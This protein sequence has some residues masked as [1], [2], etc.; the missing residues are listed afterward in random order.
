MAIGRI[1]GITIELSADTTKAVKS[2]DEFERASN[3]VATKLREINTVLKLNPASTVALSQKQEMLALRVSKVREQLAMEKEALRQLGNTP[4][5]EETIEA[6]RRLKLQIEETTVKLYEAEAAYRSFGSV[7][8]QQMAGVGKQLNTFGTKVSTV[9]S[10]L[11]RTLTLPVALL[12]GAAVKE[13]A[14]F[15]NSMAAVGAVS[16]A[17]GEE[18]DQMSSYAREL[19]ATTKFTAND[20]TDAYHY[21]ALAGWE[22]IE[23]MDGLE[24]VLNLV[25][26]SGEDLGTVSDIV[27]D[28]LTAMGEEADQ[29]GRF[30]DVF[31]VTMSKANTN[32]AQ[33]GD[34]FKY[35]APVAGAMGYEIEDLATAL[36]TMANSGIKGSMAGTA[37]RNILT[38]MVHPTDAMQA[39]MDE[40]GV[41]LYD[42]TGKMYSMAEV[43]GQLRSGLGNLAGNFLA[44]STEAQQLNAELEEGTITEDEYAEAIK[45]LIAA[46]YGAEEAHKAE[47]AAML[48]GKRGMSGLLAIVG[49]S[50]EDWNDLSESIYGSKD[51]AQTMR[52]TMENTL[53]GQL[54]ILKSQVAELAMQFG[55]AMLPSIRSI[56]G[57]LKNFVVGLQQMS[58]ETKAMIVKIAALAAAIGPLLF[59]GGKLLSGIGKL[60]MMPAG[61]TKGIAMVTTGF[62]RFSATL[63]IATGPLA[64]IVAGI[65]LVIAA[66]ISLWKNSEE[67][68]TN[69]TNSFSQVKEAGERLFEALGPGIQKVQEVFQ[70]VWN[71]FTNVMAP[72]FEGVFQTVAD[73]FS[74][75]VD[76]ILGVLEFFKGA[77]NNDWSQMWNG[78]KQIFTGLLNGLIGIGKNI[79][80]MLFNVISGILTGIAQLFSRIFTAIK[81]SVV[82]RFNWMR[83]KTAEVAQ[84]MKEAVSERIQQL[85]EAVSNRIQAMREAVVNR[86]QAMREGVANRVQALR[87]A[88]TNRIQAMREAVVSRVQALKDG[89]VNRVQALRDGVASRIQALK[90]GVVNR[91]QTMRDGV[92]N[93]IQG[94]RDSV[95][96]KVQGIKDRIT[97]KFQSARDKVVDTVQGLK[98]RVTDKIESL[99]TKVSNTFQT[100]K[101]KITSPIKKARETV[102]NAISKIK[103]LFP[104]KLGKI[105]SGI[106]LPH[107]KISGGK[108]PWGIGGKGEKPSVDIEWYKKAMQNGMV[109]DS[110][111]IFG[112]SN[113]KLL[114][115]GEAGSETVVGTGSLMNMI[116]HAAKVNTIDPDMIYEAVRQ[117]ASDAVIKNYMSGRDVTSQIERQ[118]TQNQN[119]AARFQGA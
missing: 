7:G 37:L 85:R 104:L 35:V 71:W 32:V 73:V 81:D 50:E 97:E 16:Q 22:P 25:A 119:Y 53:V 64:A 20:V 9:G 94:M 115:A 49:A 63:G 118:I 3:K 59:V 117:G 36:G 55:E 26:A 77:F 40:I 39:A 72:V 44:S 27:T 102:D 99:K 2:L 113:G 42:D 110:P 18:L 95:V 116:Q 98:Q 89:V 13:L 8:I 90:D 38:N 51:A 43:M 11:S 96:N 82:Q 15:E 1:R 70:A 62:S 106:K 109:L 66:F 46:E 52:E 69:I 33:L 61:I 4:Q 17:S 107:F 56:V 74:A 30:A 65:G 105:F 67:F 21:M 83:E 60:M 87:E 75:V 112:Y 19:A 84:L 101:E 88:V 29:S 12:G 14:T 103:E 41:T 68:R 108:I 76:V 79:L 58:P 24:G 111:T 6:Q 34:A 93:R 91:I 78:V 23:M 31:A 114:G 57:W 92:Q 100:I 10:S 45:G 86:V 80:T 5:T 28:S 54:T 47:L 48:A